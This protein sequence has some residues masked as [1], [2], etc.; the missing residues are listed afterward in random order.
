MTLNP[1]IIKDGCIA[2]E[3][4]FMK[5]PTGNRIEEKKHIIII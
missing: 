2:E 5:K 1:N 4:I 3:H